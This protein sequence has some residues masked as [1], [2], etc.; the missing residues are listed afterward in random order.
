MLDLVVLDILGPEFLG[1]TAAILIYMILF[2]GIIGIIGNQAVLAVYGSSII[3]IHIGVT[4]DVFI[5]RELTYLL[6]A[7]TFVTMGL[8]IYEESVS[9]KGRI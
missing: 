4:S 8:M 2:G 3:F 1:S 6:L 9:K 7:L 5:F